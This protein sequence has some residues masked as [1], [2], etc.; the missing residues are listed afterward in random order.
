[1][2]FSQQSEKCSKNVSKLLGISFYGKHIY[3]R[4]IRQKG[5][6]VDTFLMEY[7]CLCCG[8]YSRYAEVIPKHEAVF[9][10]YSPELLDYIQY[11]KG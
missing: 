3:G 8:F 6:Q 9:L 1:M 2:I 5:A 7:Q 10:D 4:V 11:V